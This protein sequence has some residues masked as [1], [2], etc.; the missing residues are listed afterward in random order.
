MI[1]LITQHRATRNLSRMRPS[2]ALTKSSDYLSR[3]LAARNAASKV[4][5]SGRDVA[6]RARAF[7]YQP[8]TTFDAVVAAGNLTAQQAINTW[9]AS[10]AD[11][12]VLL[13][14][15]W[16]VAGVGRTYN[17]STGR[18]HWVVE[19][20]GFWDPTIPI[21]G[22]D[23]D[24]MIDRNPS[25]RTRPPAAAI[26]AGHRFTG[27]GEDG[28][29]YSGLHCDMDEPGRY[30]W[31]DEPPQGN[32]S[33]REPSLRDNLI[34]TWHV[35]YT[36]SPTGIVHYN[37]Y[38]GYDATGFTI[39]WRIN[40][41]GTWT[42]QGYRA[43]QVPTPT[44]SGRWSSV[45]DAARD[46]EVVTFYRENGRPTATIRI[47][48]ARGVLTLFAVDGGATM[49]GFLSGVPADSNPKDDPQVIL[50]PGQGYFNAPHGPFGQ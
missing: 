6:A 16:K 49:R 48:A 19:F 17:A 24:G 4:D 14:P 38:T 47:H 45:H 7:G 9:K 32:P 46:E 20:A 5:G 39:T 35:Q 50:H 29:G 2:V 31:K 3:D 37:D 8:N 42:T 18:W 28:S 12:E 22:E 34:G 23:S 13:N 36:I 10:S 26:A 1:D 30:C 21:P 41:N 40:A 33:L 27:Y 44:E 25:I 15:A 43:Y 11:N